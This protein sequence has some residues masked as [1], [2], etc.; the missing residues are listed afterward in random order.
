MPYVSPPTSRGCD[1][2]KGGMSLDEPPGLRPR[3][4]ARRPRR[5][6]RSCRSTRPGD[7][8]VSGAGLDHLLDHRVVTDDRG[9][10]SS[11][12]GANSSPRGA[13]RSARPGCSPTSPRSMEYSSRRTHAGQHQTGAEDE[14]RG[15]GDIAPR[16]GRESGLTAGA[17]SSR[18]WSDRT[19]AC[20]RSQRPSP[21]RSGAAPACLRTSALDASTFAPSDRRPSGETP[22]ARP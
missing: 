5:R 8:G 16:A 7:V 15:E 21:R 9:P 4:A 18:G 14:A 20:C 22:P 17:R 13:S 1:C 2:S 3:S 19:A 12:D 11:P 6:V 10:G